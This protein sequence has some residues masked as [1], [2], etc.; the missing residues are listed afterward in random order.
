MFGESRLKSLIQK[1]A[2]S[3]A[4]EIIKQIFEEVQIF[5]ESEPQ[6]DDITLLIIKG[7]YGAL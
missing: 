3:S 4:S 1:N 5:S 2:S 7:K 6:F